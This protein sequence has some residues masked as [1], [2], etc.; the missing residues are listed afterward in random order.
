MPDIRCRD[1]PLPSSCAAVERAASGRA[2]ADRAGRRGSELTGRWDAALGRAGR[3][4]TRCIRINR[5]F[6]IRSSGSSGCLASAS[7]RRSAPRW[8]SAARCCK[9]CCATRWP[10]RISPASARRPQRR[11]RSPCSPARLP[12]RRP[13]SVS[14]PVSARRCS[15]PRWHAAEAESTR[16]A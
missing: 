11:L 9:E 13:P 16:I 3:R 2:R 12:V 15:S 1:A 8:R 5:A 10:I 6:S 14:S 7:R 4:S